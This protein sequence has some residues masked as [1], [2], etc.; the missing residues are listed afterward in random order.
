MNL[1]R[2]FLQNTIVPPKALD[3]A[4]AK[5]LSS[6]SS[7]FNSHEYSPLK[8]AMQWERS[9]LNIWGSLKNI[10]EGEHWSTNFFRQNRFLFKPST[11]HVREERDNVGE[12]DD[13]PEVF[14]TVCDAD[15]VDLGWKDLL[16]GDWFRFFG[17]VLFRYVDWYVELFLSGLIC[18]IDAGFAPTDVV[19]L[20]DTI[21]LTGLVNWCC[22]K[23]LV[24]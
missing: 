2:S 8:G 12:G 9:E 1:S 4:M 14:I 23:L 10:S 19:G 21:S 3:L 16:N 24:W 18:T 20:S 15:G 22:V 6:F 5:S 17:R 11:F 7:E 13:D